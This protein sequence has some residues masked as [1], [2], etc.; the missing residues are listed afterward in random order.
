MT[1][2]QLWGGPKDGETIRNHP[3]LTLIKRQ[4]GP[5]RYIY[6]ATPRHNQAGHQL[7]ECVTRTAAA[8]NHP[9]HKP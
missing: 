6:A 9:T 4:H 7:Y 2:V 1:T 3:P 8:P 5:W